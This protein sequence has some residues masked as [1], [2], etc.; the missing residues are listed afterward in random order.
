MPSSVPIDNYGEEEI[1][2]VA[3]K[4]RIGPLKAKLTTKLALARAKENR[5]PSSSQSAASLKK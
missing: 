5:Q 2:K 1:K 4:P 3:R